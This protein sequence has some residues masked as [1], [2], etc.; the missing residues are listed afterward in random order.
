MLARTSKIEIGISNFKQVIE[1]N[2]FYVDK[3]LFISDLLD[4]N[5]PVTLI[6]RPRGFGKSLNLD[7]LRCFFDLTHK[8]DEGLF[9]RL[10]IWQLDQ[11]YKNRQ[12]CYPTISISF[13]GLHNESF[14]SA[15]AGIVAAISAV[16]KDFDYLLKSPI[17]DSWYVEIYKSIIDGNASPSRYQDSLSILCEHLHR[18]HNTKVLLLIDDYDAPM[19]EAYLHGYWSEM[20]YFMLGLLGPIL[21]DNSDLFKGVLVGITRGTKPSSQINNIRVDTLRDDHYAAYFGLT[22]VEVS[23]ALK[24]LNLQDSLG[25]LKDWYNGYLFGN[26][27]VLF[28]PRSIVHFLHSQKLESYGTNTIDNVIFKK[29]ARILPADGKQQLEQLMGGEEIEARID[30]F[31]TYLDLDENGSAD[32]IWSLFLINGYL[33]CTGEASND[34]LKLKVPNRD[35][36]GIYEQAVREW[37]ETSSIRPLFL[38]S[39]KAL[40]DGDTQLLETHLGLIAEQTYSQFETRLDRPESFYHGFILAMMLN[41]RDRYFIE[42]NKQSGY[43]CYDIF[44]EPLDKQSLGFIIEFKAFKKYLGHKDWEQVGLEALQQIED[45]KYETKLTEKGVLRIKTLAIVFKGQQVKVFQGR[46]IGG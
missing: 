37:F 8:S 26:Q 27:T 19:E 34:R 44:L 7:M 17:L 5:D 33:K 45:R 43:S 41:L 13:K 31:R 22:K 10:K 3:S 39:I 46:S 25:D 24:A 23:E 2:H 35:I 40:L 42:S 4:S 38:A 14:E 1:E 32:C 15:Y 30:K 11:T 18:F 12:G 28:N 6:T 9:H 16:F 21:K 20:E 29:C 36:M